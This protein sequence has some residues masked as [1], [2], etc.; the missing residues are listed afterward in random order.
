MTEQKNIILPK[1]ITWNTLAFIGS[2]KLL[3]SSF[4]DS[5]GFIKKYSEKRKKINQNRMNKHD[6]SKFNF[7][8][9]VEIVLLILIS[10]RE[11][12]MIENNVVI[13]QRI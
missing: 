5:R 8:L 9:E 11:D 3:N 2:F 10:L 13:I 4:T 7:I 12:T 1:F 6:I